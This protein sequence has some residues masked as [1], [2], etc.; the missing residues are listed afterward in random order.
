MYRP[1]PSTTPIDVSDQVLQKMKDFR[2]ACELVWRKATAQQCRRNSLY[3]KRVNGPFYKENEHVLFHYPVVPVGQHPKLS[4]AWCDPFRILMCLIDVNY[5][6]KK[7]TTGKVQDVHYDS[8]KRYHGPVLNSCNFRTRPTTHSTGYQPHPVPDFN[9]SQCSHFFIPFTFAPQMTFPD[10]FNC[11]TSP[12]LSLILIAG[13]FPNPSLSAT[14]PLLLYSA[15]QCS[16]PFATKSIDHDRRFLT[17]LFIRT[18]SI[19]PPHGRNLDASP[20]QEQLLSSLPHSLTLS[21]MAFLKISVS[22][23]K[24]HQSRTVLQHSAS[25]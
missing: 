22:D 2:Q 9:H 12:F 13:L 1:P 7:L 15:C 16:V 24:V 20:L 23:S 21:L 5:Q 17:I 8:L 11:P 4:S 19:S 10:P 18:R 6:I 14:P 25:L 3:N